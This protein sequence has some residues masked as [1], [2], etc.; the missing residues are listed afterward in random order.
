LREVE[1]SVTLRD[2]Q[3][4][5]VERLKAVIGRRPILV[6]PTGSGKTTMAV[7]LVEELGVPTLWLAHRKELIDQAAQ[8]LE[9]LG[10]WPGRIMAGYPPAPFAQVQVAS[11]QTLIRRQMPPARLVVIDEAHHVATSSYGRILEQYPDA[12]VLGLTATPFRLDGRGL[13]DV[14]GEILV[15]ARTDELCQAG[16][17]HDPRVYAGQSP[18]LRHVKIAMGDYALSELSRRTNTEELNADLVKTWLGKSPGRRTVAFAVDIEHSQAIA[19]AFQAAG[20]PAEH[21]DGGTPRD[22]RE[23]ILERLRGGRTLVVSNCM[24]LT[25]GWD[26]PALETA[27]IAR[28]TAS[29]NL[30]LQMI[31]RIMR[32]CPDKDGAIVLDHAGNHHVHGRV[33]RRLEYT[34]DSGKK[35]GESDPLRLRRCRACQLLFDPGDPCCPE[36]GWAP[37]PPV[38]ERPVIHG[39][40]QLVE[41]DD[42][43]FAYRSHFWRLMEAQRMAAGYKPGWSAYRFKERFGEW[44]VVADGEL[45]DPDRATL[46]DK[47]AVY[48]GFLRQAGEKGFKPGWAAYR[49][50]EV[51]GCWPRGF[52]DE[53]RREALSERFARLV[54]A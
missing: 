13:G 16:V 17:L 50:R 9:E 7:A 10:L 4:R 20:V 37:P 3:R 28:P 51:F 44:P 39:V 45:V 26:L 27:I 24:V 52:V 5:A 35:I 19:A 8:H 54:Q 22:E 34:L 32:A 11:V 42:G 6:A 46:D 49:Y 18:D 2:Y 21:L 29:L 12:H 36:C 23:A 53:V 14:F 38:R 48:V 33:T 15:A 30:H 40:A 43:D 1:M 25:E 47:R 41:F 31:G